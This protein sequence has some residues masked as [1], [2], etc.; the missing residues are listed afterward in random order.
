MLIVVPETAV[1]GMAL[2]AMV[3]GS[4]GFNVNGALHPAC[5]EALIPC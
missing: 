3:G 1:V 4:Y 5:C 2:Q